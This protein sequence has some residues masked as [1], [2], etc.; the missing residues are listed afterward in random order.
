MG[1]GNSHEQIENPSKWGLEQAEQTVMIDPRFRRHNNENHGVI[2]LP[3]IGTRLPAQA[4]LLLGTALVILLSLSLAWQTHQAMQLLHASTPP[5]SQSASQPVAAADPVSLLP[6]FGTPAKTNSAPPTT[7]L[8]LSLLGSF[9]NPDSQ[10]SSA[11]IR[12]DD[13]KPQRFRVGDNVQDGIRLHA[14]Y[15][16]RIELERQGHLETLGFPR[17]ASAANRLIS[18]QSDS[19]EHSSPEDMA[20]ASATAEQL[21]MLQDD[22]FIQL[23]ERMAK[24]REQMGSA[25]PSTTPSE[26]TSAETP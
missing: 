13:G 8:R 2:N 20:N 12:K 1:S 15:P 24:L 7:N 26:P 25:E 3:F 4:P 6:L 14:V 9:V 21:E 17:R 5:L 10:R 18:S 16:D 22:E 19:G 23:R 11:I